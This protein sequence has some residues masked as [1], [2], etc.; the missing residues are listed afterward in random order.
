MENLPD[1]LAQ[2]TQI[3]TAQVKDAAPKLDIANFEPGSEEIEEWLVKFEFLIG[4]LDEPTKSKTLMTK[5]S[6][7]AFTNLRQSILPKEFLELSYNEIKAKL[8]QLY[9]TQQSIHIDRVNCLQF[10]R[11]E[12]ED[13]IPFTNRLKEA[14]HKFKYADFNEQQFKCLILLTSLKAGKDEKLR[15]YILKELSDKNKNINFDSLIAGI[16]AIL[17]ASSEAKLLEGHNIMAFKQPFQG[18][19]HF[20]KEQHHIPAAHSSN[21]DSTAKPTSSRYSCY[22]CGS[23]DH[24][25][26]NC[27]HY[28]HVCRNCS[29]RGHLEAVCR[30]KFVSGKPKQGNPKHGNTS[31]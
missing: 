12:G 3:V 25:C 21:K 11:T 7:T 9:T 16:Q 1:I 29:I 20:S 24:W 28:K 23:N 6:A 10:S 15:Q 2:L 17:T 31:N 30:N 27:P 13:F 14:L 8:I 4:T 26:K 19:K 18:P 5:L 22:R